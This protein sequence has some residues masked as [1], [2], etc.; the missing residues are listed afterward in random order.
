M[1]KDLEIYAILVLR[2]FDKTIVASYVNPKEDIS[3][4]GV[5]ECVASNMNIIAGKRYSSQGNYQSI[6][7]IIDIH[8]RVYS[9]VTNPEFPLKL[10]FNCLEEISSSFHQKFDSLVAK[11]TEQSL[12]ANSRSLF[13][14]IFIK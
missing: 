12:S 1:K 13:Q 4:E 2:Y 14:E 7:Y 9:L 8:G 5:R 6:H 11:A 10:A 3:I